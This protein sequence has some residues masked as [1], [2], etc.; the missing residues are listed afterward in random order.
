MIDIETIK[1]PI[2]VWHYFPTGNAIRIVHLVKRNPQLTL[3]MKISM[4]AEGGFLIDKLYF[5]QPGFEFSVEERKIQI[6]DSDIVKY[7]TMNTF[8]EKHETIKT[9]FGYLK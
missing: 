4:T 8:P 1:L 5:M 6:D 9:V 3:D 7:S 2:W